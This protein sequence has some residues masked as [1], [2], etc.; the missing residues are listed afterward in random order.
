M[1][2][3]R[4][5]GVAAF[6]AW[7]DAN[8]WVAVFFALVLFAGTL[9]AFARVVANTTDQ[10]GSVE[11]AYRRIVGGFPPH[12][13]EP[14]FAGHFVGRHLVVLEHGDGLELYLYTQ[15][16]PARPLDEARV[17]STF[18][19]VFEFLEIEW[20]EVQR[21]AVPQGG[22]TI[23]VRVLQLVDAQGLYVY[24]FPIRRSHGERA[25]LVLYGPQKEARE[26]AKEIVERF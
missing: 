2:V 3:Q 15:R 12:G 24:L 10:P 26:M 17:D 4:P 16:W 14:S 25:M 1:R 11:G 22:G 9:W 18:E 7:I 23:T 19:G 21:G 5:T 8:V 6:R 20:A 13:F